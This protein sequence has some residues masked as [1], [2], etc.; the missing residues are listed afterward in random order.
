M[1]EIL[2]NNDKENNIIFSNNSNKL[3]NY[4]INNK[5][6]MVSKKNKSRQKGNYI[7]EE[8]IGEGAFAKVKLAKHIITGEKVAI[9]ILPKKNIESNI[10]PTN[11]INSNN[12]SKIQKEINIL[13]SLH[14]KNIIQLYEII[15]TKNHLYI[16]MEY[17]E[18]KELFDY[19]VNRKRLSEREAC[20]YFQQIIN[21]VE[22]LHLCNITHRDLKPENIL[23]DNR[24]RIRISDF[25]LSGISK[26]NNS[27]LS[28]PC[29][30]PLY[31]PP[32]ML[33]GDKYDGVYSDIWSCGIILYV[34]LVGDLPYIDSKEKI[35]YQNIM[36]HNYYYPET[37]SDNAVDLIEHMLKI[38]PNERYGFKEIKE[39]PWFNIIT[40]KLRPGIIYNVHK[41]PVDEKI[42]DKIEKMGIDKNLCRKSAL[43]NNYDSYMAI[44]LLTLKQSIRKGE[45]S[46]SDLFSEQYIKYINDYNNW[47]DPSKINSPLFYE[48]NVVNIP[49]Y[50]LNDENINK[51]DLENIDILYDS[52]RN[53][54][55][56]DN[57]LDNS[58]NEDNQN[59]LDNINKQTGENK[60]SFNNQVNENKRLIIKNNIEKEKK[61]YSD[62]KKDNDKSY[63][64][65]NF[66]SNINIED[67]KP[68]L[69]N[70]NYHLTL[71]NSKKLFFKKLQLKEQNNNNKFKKNKKLKFYNNEINE[72]KNSI[73]INK[74]LYKKRNG[75]E[76]IK[77][78]IFINQIEKRGSP[79]KLNKSKIIINNNNKSL[80]SPI[81]DNKEINNVILNDKVKF[82]QTINIT[83]R[84]NNSII[85]KKINN[86]FKKNL[87]IE[88]SDFLDKIFND[89][90]ID[91]ENNA[92]LNMTSSDNLD[93]NNSD[94][95]IL[96]L[97][98]ENTNISINSGKNNT[99]NNTLKRTK[100]EINSIKK[101]N[102]NKIHKKLNISKKEKPFYLNTERSRIPK[103]LK[104]QKKL[105][106]I[107]LVEPLNSNLKNQLKKEIENDINK[108]DNDLKLIDDMDDFTKNKFYQF[109]N[110]RSIN[111][112]MNLFNMEDFANKLIKT[113]IFKNY[114]MRKNKN[115]KKE[116]N[117]IEDTFYILEKYKNSLGLIEK[118]KNKVFIDKLSNFNYYTFDQYLNDEDDKIISNHLLKNKMLSLFIKKAKET[119][120][121]NSNISN[122]RTFSKNIPIHSNNFMNSNYTNLKSRS[123]TPNCQFN[124]IVMN[125]TQNNF[126][127][128]KYNINNY[129]D[130]FP[131]KN[132]K[133]LILY[134]NNLDN[135]RKNNLSHSIDIKRNKN[136]S[137]EKNN[138]RTKNRSITKRLTFNTSQN[139]NRNLN[140]DNNSNSSFNSIIIEE[141]NDDN[142]NDYNKKLIKKMNKNNS[143]KR[144][145]HKRNHAL[146]LN[147]ILKTENKI[148][149]NKKK[150]FNV[151]MNNVNIESN[152]DKKLIKINLGNTINGK[153]VRNQTNEKRIQKKNEIY[154]MSDSKNRKKKIIKN[155]MNNKELKS[156]KN[157]NNKNDNTNIFKE[158]EI[159]KAINNHKIKN[160][161]ELK[162]LNGNY[163]IDINNIILKSYDEIKNKIKKYCQKTKYSIIETDNNIK[164]LKN[165]FILDMY[166]Y[167]LKDIEIN[168]VYIC[169]KLKGDRKKTFKLINDLLFYFHN[170]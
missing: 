64:S 169:F 13:R 104:K 58:S 166:F 143:N 60:E 96:F 131:N 45:E 9:K 33:R 159:K 25:G 46:I 102:T 147:K 112:N 165:G 108:F 11:N 77:N 136:K 150:Y 21:G 123:K 158:N 82:N 153:R 37:I 138:N 124:N 119:L 167:T 81:L 78:R 66:S 142:N 140:L 93:D 94:S 125:K 53:I 83:D 154:L 43:E 61:D 55:M 148:L 109:D 51:I 20:R 91:L 38:D 32:E 122:K 48:Y 10:S 40:P 75:N 35:I 160:K 145:L 162:E 74:H 63:D 69:T 70:N 8:T 107:L 1:L 28:T 151:A 152:S 26:D 52:D 134:R 86:G 100:I 80:I 141:G 139:S 130:L 111:E 164:I 132:K 42:L 56:L 113:T 117:E 133:K 106:T 76:I 87:K 120:F 163:I 118:L 16:V 98:D 127:K 12:S 157:V 2:K 92:K 36:T 126:Y 146:T 27:K 14:H 6:I 19:I 39:H 68:T 114:L 62:V 161:N 156:P 99:I 59:Y 71:N 44:Y 85:K 110:D 170:N 30:T 144:V 15:E 49:N 50:D 88:D 7:L 24:K 17:C 105:D 121:N 149:N 168:N 34:M 65:I 31:A 115:I 18:G 90:I 72:N 103:N 4:S 101:I 129:N 155:L 84:N 128:Q 67:D 79:P 95:K 54:N 47:I 23:L 137:K 5:K 97:K 3:N 41:I 57:N 116:K 29:G 22:Y 135:I 73:K 89:N